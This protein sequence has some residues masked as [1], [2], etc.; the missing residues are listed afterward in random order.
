M[1]SVVSL[2]MILFSSFKSFS[3]TNNFQLILDSGKTEFKN[4]FSQYYPDYSKAHSLLKQAV[5]AEPNNAEARYFFAYVLDKMNTL[6]GLDSVDLGL[7][8]EVSEQF[9]TVN[10][11]Q[12]HYDGEFMLLDPYSK[13]TANWGS[14]GFYYLC[15]SK[16]DSAIWALKEGK[17]RGGFS[18]GILEYNRQIRRSSCLNTAL[19]KQEATSAMFILKIFTC[20][21]KKHRLVCYLVSTV[22]IL[23]AM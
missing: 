13:L 15:K 20:Q 4:Q 9:E 18:D 17:K 8:F 21:Q 16:K 2:L 7:T 22:R 3:Q 23:S 14:L 19:I 6:N 5:S 1:R 12:Q 11:L 10:K